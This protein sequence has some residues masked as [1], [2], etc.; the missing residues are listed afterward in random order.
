MTLQKEKIRSQPH[1]GVI[2]GTGLVAGGLVAVLASIMSP[3]AAI[4]IGG[5]AAGGLGLVALWVTRR[6]RARRIHM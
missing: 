4:A 5:I 6:R 1:V 2:V 3:L